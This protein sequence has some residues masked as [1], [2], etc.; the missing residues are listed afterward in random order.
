MYAAGFNPNPEIIRVLIN[1]GAKIDEKNINGFT[2]LMWAERN[3]PNA[4]IIAILREFMT[5]PKKGNSKERD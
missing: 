5:K 4:E 1:A 2:P 3:N